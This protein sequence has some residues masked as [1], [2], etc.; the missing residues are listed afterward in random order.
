M[1]DTTT[2]FNASV[3]RRLRIGTVSIVPKVDDPSA[4]PFK[5]LMMTIGLN[6]GNL[7]FTQ[8][9]Y[10][11]LD[12]DVAHVGFSINPAHINQNFDILVVPAANW[13][14]NYSEWDGFV[15]SLEKITIPV[16]VIGLGLQA[17]SM[18]ITQVKV[19]DSSVRLAHFFS[20]SAHVMSVRGDFTKEW[21]AS[22]GI[23]N[24][25]TTG[26]PSLYMNIFNDVPESVSDSIS[27]QPT[28]YGLAS[29]FV[30]STGI[31]RRL[32][33][34]SGKF[35][36]PIIFQSESEEIEM[37][38]HKKT[39]AEIAPEKTA[40]WAE[41]YEKNDADE[42]ESHLQRNGKVFFDVAA[43]SHFV[44]RQLGNIGTRL[45]GSIISLNSGRPAYLIPHDSRTQEVADFAG[46]PIL[47]QQDASKL[48]TL[49]DMRCLIKAETL[50]NY[51]DVRAKNQ[52]TFIQFLGD[53]GINP[54]FECM[55]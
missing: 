1:S 8:A 20:Q 24:V 51:R 6:T 55:F 16:V 10:N 33:G 12:A 32:F 48:E 41:L 2:S 31:N 37:L 38:V 29:S 50:D 49:D 7:M 36:L 30:K 43:W 15:D 4:M 46:I 5:Q 44:A 21:L 54:K 9:M 19:S 47:T 27:I 35:D 14:N 3:S 34:L 18:D 13:L 45:H 22:L 25:T 23:T 42:L 39:A 28:R 11:L 26:C 52:K 17:E 53:V 40:I